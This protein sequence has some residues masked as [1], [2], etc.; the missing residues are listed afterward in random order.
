M[1]KVKHAPSRHT[2]TPLAVEINLMGAPDNSSLSHFSAMTRP[3]WL[4]G[5]VRNRLAT[6]SSRHRVDGAED[7]AMMQ[8]ERAV[9]F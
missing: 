5:A 6:P 4:R 9:K 2:A 7:D 3:C 1:R 8:H